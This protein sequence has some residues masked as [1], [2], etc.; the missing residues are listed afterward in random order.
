[1]KIETPVELAAVSFANI[2][3]LCFDY[4][5]FQKKYKDEYQSLKESIKLTPHSLSKRKTLIMSFIR[6]LFDNTISIK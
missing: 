4:L 6:N 2:V 5:D 3:S 1:M